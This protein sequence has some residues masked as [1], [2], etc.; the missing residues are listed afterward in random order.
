MFENLKMSQN[1]S[2]IKM[3][4]GGDKN[5]LIFLTTIYLLVQILVLIGIL[6]FTIYLLK[7]TEQN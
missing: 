4:P 1:K 6:V 7:T 5:T 3:P 2:E